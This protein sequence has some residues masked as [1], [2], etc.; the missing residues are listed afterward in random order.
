LNVRRF[1][2]VD[3]LNAALADDIVRAVEEQ[4]A[5]YIELSGGQSPRAVYELLGCGERRER[6]AS[7]PVCWI[8]GDERFV[9]PG[10]DQSNRKMIETTLFREGISPAHRFLFFETSD[11]DPATA[12][13][14]FEE[15]WKRA[16]VPALD[17]AVL[18]VGDDGHTASLFPEHEILEE[19]SR[20]ARELWAAHLDM[21]RLTLTLPV[22]RAAKSKLVLA[23]GEK[24]LG[25]LER[26]R[27]GE[28][29]PITRVASGGDTTWY[30]S[31]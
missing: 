15:E 26:V 24:K 17:L 8:V 1:D 28:D 18:G 21:W 23:A 2:S 20:I 5:R 11:V 22:L 19:T 25:I 13:L 4:G 3:L 9:D 7:F 6:L 16:A 29:L 31:A 30:V 12:A 10:D 14:R 27:N